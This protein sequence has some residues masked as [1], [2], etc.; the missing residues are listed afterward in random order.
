VAKEQPW[1]N[2]GLTKPEWIA[3][4]VAK[5]VNAGKAWGFADG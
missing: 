2:E 3:R 4:E 5:A 1:K